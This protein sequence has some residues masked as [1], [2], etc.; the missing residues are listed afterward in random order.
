[1]PPKLNIDISSIAEHP[2]IT[3]GGTVHIGSVVVSATGVTSNGLTQCMNPQDLSFSEAWCLGRGSSGSVR[4]V[5]RKD[6]GEYIALKEIKVTSQSHLQEIER[7]L[8]TLHSA[9]I[10]P[11]PFLVDF[12]GAYSHDGSVF[13]AMEC[14]DGSL[15][16][17][18]PV[19]SI[20]MLARITRNVLSGLAYLHKLRY[21]VHRDLKP[22]NV[23]FNLKGVVKISDFGVSTTLECSRDNTQSFVGTVTYMSPERLRGEPYSFAADIWSLGIVVA[24]LLLGSHPFADILPEGQGS[25]GRFWALLQHLSSDVRPV[26]LPSD[27]NPLLADFVECCLRKD[28]A[29]RSTST[30]LLEHLFITSFAPGSDQDNQL[31]LQQW[32]KTKVTPSTTPAAT[33]EKKLNLDDAL[34]R[35]ALLAG[36]SKKR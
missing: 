3:Q 34:G 5:K 26:T 29:D 19:D 12:H 23:L 10:P 1:M 28:P 2:D 22:G 20:E 6:T 15:A 30:A 16:D 4:R 11:S 14:M 21:L 33:D 35:L 8:K 31:A 25:E 24:E 13:I 9:Q 18:R 36:S 7:E 17:L 27:T 32:L